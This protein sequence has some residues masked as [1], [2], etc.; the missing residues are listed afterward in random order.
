RAENSNTSR[1]L[2]EFWMVEQEAA[3][4]D[5][6][7][8]CSLASSFLK[9]VIGDVLNKC[10]FEI[11]FLEEH[12]EKGLRQKLQAVVDKDF[13]RITYT[14]AISDLEKAQKDGKTFEYPISWG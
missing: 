1:H 7:G 13:K 9:R 4:M 14:T 10:S 5:L 6:D 2:A 8:L 3:F 12:F 11:D